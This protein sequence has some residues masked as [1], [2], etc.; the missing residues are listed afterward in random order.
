MN[1]LT[2]AVSKLPWTSRCWEAIR[3][4]RDIG[5]LPH[6]LLVTGPVGV[7]KRALVETAAHALLCADLRDKDGFACGNCQECRLLRAGTHPDL[8]R[9]GPDP[10]SK[11]HEI[12]VDAI[13]GLCASDALTSHRGGRKVVVL[14]PAQNMNASAANSLLKTLEEPSEGSV[15]FLIC[16]RSDRLPATVRS[17]CQHLGVTVP[18]ESVALEW[19]RGHTDAD[20]ILLALR[21]AQGA[22]LRALALLEEGRLVDRARIFAGFIEVAGRRRDPISEAGVWNE[23]EPSILFD[24][25]CGWV[26]DLARLCSGHPGPL[27]R[28]PDKCEELRGLARILEPAAVHRFLQ[29][30]LDLRQNETS[31]MNRLLLYESLL[32]RWAQ[33]AQSGVGGKGVVGS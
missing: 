28:N 2:Q 5:R 32:I 24:W 30:I 33:L 16:E 22:P 21:L 27:L 1:P 19:L 7:G 31:S 25:L 9:I 3:R 23:T 13:R 20:D 8:L 29:E 4:A 15:L 17:R 14:D 26:C 11:S 18:S 6:A 10:E 12:K